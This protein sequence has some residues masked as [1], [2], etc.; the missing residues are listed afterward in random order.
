MDTITISYFYHQGL[1]SLIIWLLFEIST[2]SLSYVFWEWS[3]QWEE[4]PCYDDYHHT[5]IV[6]C[7][8]CLILFGLGGLA[9]ALG[10]PDWINMIINPEY[11]AL[12]STPSV[13]PCGR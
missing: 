13:S 7:A 1:W 2:A 11:Y 12:T 4:R 6:T 10:L 8:I 9:G 3:K 5:I